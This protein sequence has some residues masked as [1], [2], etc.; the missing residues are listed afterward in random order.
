MNFKYCLS[1]SMILLIKS[2]NKDTYV[3]LDRQWLKVYCSELDNCHFKKTVWQ[4]KTFFK[5]EVGSLIFLEIVF[6]PVYR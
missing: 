5:K 2:F 6:I 1:E 4:K 3:I